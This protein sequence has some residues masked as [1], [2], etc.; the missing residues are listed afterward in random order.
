MSRWTSP[1]GDRFQRPP[2][3]C[4]STSHSI[5]PN[6]NVPFWLL[7]VLVVL[8]TAR[9][10]HA[11][12]HLIGF[13]N[14]GNTGR[15]AREEAVRAIPFDQ[16]TDEMRNRIQDV[17]AKPTIYRRMP[18]HS[19]ECDHQLYLFLI[20][21]PEVVVNIWEVMGATQIELQR[22]GPYAFSATDGAGTTSKVE[23]AYGTK[24]LHIFYGDG[25]Y[26]GSML[27]NRVPGRAVLVLRSQYQ[28]GP[29]GDKVV[30]SMLDMFVELDNATVDVIAKTLH[31]IIGR[32]ADLN[33]LE[34]AAFV[35]R[36]SQATG[37]H[38]DAMQRLAG[39]LKNV[40]P[41]V[42]RQFAEIAGKVASDAAARQR[43]SRSTARVP[44]SIRPTG[45]ILEAPPQFDQISRYP[46]DYPL[47]R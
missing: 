28:Q 37:Q 27:K 6:T 1:G 34:S 3:R 9:T 25:F 23:L 7:F 18:K 20:R 38:G 10:T 41:E 12:L 47:L 21:N 22:T 29:D 14:S 5:A 33:F 26:E 11:Q 32:F 15:Q 44:V 13:R 40:S 39:R 43:S 4:L 19:M 17:V 35:G 24:N 30:N 36:L 2:S 46:A 42:R 45:A 16:L 31:P 8:A